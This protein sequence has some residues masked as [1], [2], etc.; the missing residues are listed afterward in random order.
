MLATAGFDVLLEDPLVLVTENSVCANDEGNQTSETV[1]NLME[2]RTTVG[3][4]LAELL[5]T[6]DSSSLKLSVVVGT[7]ITSSLFKQ[8][9]SILTG[10]SSETFSTG[11]S[12]VSIAF[13]P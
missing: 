2:L 10:L 12:L 7:G 9:K 6:K 5:S 11:Q 3:L 8:L 4:A 13:F 1:F